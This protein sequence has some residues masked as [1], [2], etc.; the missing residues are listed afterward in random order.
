L[1]REGGAESLGEKEGE[2]R[3]WKESGEK[4]LA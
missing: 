2:R 3:R 4:L 1:R